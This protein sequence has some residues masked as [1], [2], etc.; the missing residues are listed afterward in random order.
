MWF[1]KLLYD[2]ALNYAFGKY[3]QDPNQSLKHQSWMK[4]KESESYASHHAK[5]H[6]KDI[7]EWDASR[8][9]VSS[10]RSHMRIF[11]SANSSPIS[12]IRMK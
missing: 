10:K 1:F 9:R 6:S 7:K 3:A 8:A 5:I 2:D 4:L 11:A 12:N